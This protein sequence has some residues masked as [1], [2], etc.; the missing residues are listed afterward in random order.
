MFFRT[1]IV[2]DY[3]LFV[4]NTGNVFKKRLSDIQT[5]FKLILFQ[6]GRSL[7]SSISGGMSSRVVC[8]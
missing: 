2:P 1:N 5:A 7:N 4:V 8:D 6:N 3:Q